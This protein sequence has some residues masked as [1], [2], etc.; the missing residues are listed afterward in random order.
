MTM[1]DPFAPNVL[2]R[3]S[4]PPRKVV[5]LRASRIGDFICTTPAFR[6]LRAALPEAEITLITLSMLRDLVERSPHLDRFVAF[7][8]YPGIA[9][10]FFDACKAASFFQA[11]QAER[12]DLAIQLQGSGVNS[13]PFMLMLGARCTV[14]FIRQGDSPGL[15]DAALPW[16]LRGHEIQRM[17]SLPRFLGIP[18]HCTSTYTEFPLWPQDHADAERLLAGAKRPLI[19]LHTA[20]RDVTRRWPLDRFLSAAQ[21]LH[22]RHN[23]TIVILGEASEQQAGEA[24]AQAAGA[25]ACLNLAGKTSLPTLGA[26]LARLSLLITN[27]SG[28]AHMAYALNTPTVT[29]F[30]GASPD[31]YAPLQRG[32]YRIVLYEMPCRPCNYV[33]CPIGNACLQAVTVEHVLAA[34]EEVIHINLTP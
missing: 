24:I 18:A 30:G 22:H 14:G 13:N 23:G 25:A 12:F 16:P 28:P 31:S 7:P 5:L 29:I 17:L 19:G 34:A 15:L 1:R 26:I 32:P 33:V 3:M 9:E 21:T 8:G 20:A 2:Q 10:Q 11:M 6:A 4:E 27:D